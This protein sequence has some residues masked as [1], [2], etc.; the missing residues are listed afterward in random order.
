MC[1]AG[2]GRPCIDMPRASFAAETIANGA[3]EAVANKKRKRYTACMLFC[4][5]F[6]WAVASVISGH[7]ASHYDPESAT[8]RS[9]GSPLTLCG[10][11]TCSDEPQ[12]R[13]TRAESTEG[14]L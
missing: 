8:A 13:V 2:M 5:V 3:T 9:S 7:I 11:S 14:A 6:S 12:R 4:G 10:R 1:M